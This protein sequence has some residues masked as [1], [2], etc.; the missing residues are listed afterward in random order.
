MA[1]LN[2]NSSHWMI[3]DNRHWH[4]DNSNAGYCF[5]SNPHYAGHGDDA[6]AQMK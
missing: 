2:N 5:R 4:R 1:L 6:F 3:D